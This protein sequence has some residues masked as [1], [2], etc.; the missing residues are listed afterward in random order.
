MG[1][2]DVKK[3]L[4]RSVIGA[5]GEP[6]VFKPKSGGAFPIN[7]VVDR[8][9]VEVSYG[10]GPAVS[11]FRTIADINIDDLPDEPKQGDKLVIGETEF[12]IVDSRSD[13]GRMR[14]LVLNK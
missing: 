11:H 12:T 6:V 9:W 13:G 2:S 10:D 5:F 8:S 7:A 1:W 14:E 4:A 3:Q